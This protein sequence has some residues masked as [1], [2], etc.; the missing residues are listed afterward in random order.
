MGES[1]KAGAKGC[2]VKPFD[3]PRLLE[4]I[5]KIFQKEHVLL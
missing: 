1:I 2:I 3:P 5:E 4:E